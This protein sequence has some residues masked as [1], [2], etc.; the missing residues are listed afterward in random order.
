[1]LPTLKYKKDFDKIMAT[2]V[3]VVILKNKNKCDCYSEEEL[4][5]S[6]PS[7]YCPKCYGT[8]YERNIILT[9]KIRHEVQTNGTGT[10]Y[11]KTIYNTSINEIRVFFMPEFY[12][13]ISTEDLIGTLDDTEKNI[14]SIYKV[15]NKERYNAEDFVYYEIYGEKLNFL[16]NLSGIEVPHD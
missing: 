12:K 8:G 14:V 7:P 5:D 13:F 3:P 11:E 2:G 4:I 1:M 6:E 15:V 10:Y 9:D 16:S